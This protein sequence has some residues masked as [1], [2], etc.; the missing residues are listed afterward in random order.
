V[1]WLTDPRTQAAYAAV[2]A[3][4]LVLLIKRMAREGWSLAGPGDAA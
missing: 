4:L 2:A 3:T 1:T